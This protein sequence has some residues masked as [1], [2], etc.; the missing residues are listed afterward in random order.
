MGRDYDDIV[1]GTG[2]GVLRESYAEVEEK[3]R[4]RARATGVPVEAIKQRLGP[5]GGTSGE[6]ADSLKDFVDA[7]LGLLTTSFYDPGDVEVFA[8]EVIPQIK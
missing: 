5:A 1:K 3:I 8:G 2:F 6:V 7:G 4:Q